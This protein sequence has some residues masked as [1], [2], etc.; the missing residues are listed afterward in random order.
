MIFKALK[1]DG[2]GNDFLIIDNRSQSINLKP[3]QIQKLSNRE[4]GIG[5]DQLISIENSE[6]NDAEIKYFNS[7]GKT[8]NACGNGNRCVS[9]ILL[10]ETTNET[11]NFKV[12]N[13]IHLGKKI[14][15]GVMEVSMPKPTQVLHNI[16]VTSEVNENPV[17]IEIKQKKLTGHLVNVGNPHI[18]FFE[19]ISDE[20][21]KEMGPL[22]EN[23][24][25]FPD[26]TNVTF[27]DIKDKNNI[28]V[29][30][31][32]RGAGKTLACGTAACA[33]AFV[34]ISSDLANDPVNIHFK[35]GFLKIRI[36]Q[37]KTLLMQGP[38]SQR[39]EISVEI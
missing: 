4:N 11:V 17:K 12:G 23:H 33:T 7:D 36:N 37:D 35:L 22:I 18:I 5:F 3:E 24:Q 20:K 2:L 25:I 19:A 32:E 14:S 9:D 13:F 16:P 15:E 30:V 21:L 26:R 6:Q 27:A 1:M 29:N 10:S 31:W 8:A 38:I 39:Q 28:H 34:A